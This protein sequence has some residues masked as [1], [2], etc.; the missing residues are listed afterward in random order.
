MQTELQKPIVLYRT[1]LACKIGDSAYLDPVNHPDPC[2]LVSNKKFVRTSVVKK[3]NK[4]TGEIE[5]LNTIYKPLNEIIM[6]EKKQISVTRALAELKTLDARIQSAVASGL[7]CTVVIGAEEKPYNRSEKDKASIDNTI[8]S[9]FDSV[10]DLITRRQALKSAVLQS[11]AVTKVT[12]S[13]KEM[14]VAEAIDTKSVIEQKRIF[15]QRMKQQVSLATTTVTHLET[16]MNESIE[17]AVSAIHGSEK[18]KVSSEAF[19][20]VA[21]PIRA[22]HAPKVYSISPIEERIRSL[23]KEIEE[24]SIE[25]DFS[26]SEVNSKTLIEV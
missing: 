10:G 25:V 6:S 24:F 23:E 11:N 17:K 3:Y 22:A 12:I 20:L 1:L 21:K 2:G 13:G 5:T 26:L 4:Q 8:K 7:F 15:L 18:N 16:K 19:E 14:T 9:S